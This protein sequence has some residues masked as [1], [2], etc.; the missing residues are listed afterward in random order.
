[1][2][3][4]NTL[5]A[6]HPSVDFLFVYIAEAH[7]ADLWPIGL[8]EGIESHKTMADRLQQAS[9]FAQAYDLTM[10]VVCD[11][12]DNSVHN[13]FAAWPV[14][15]YI[16]GADGRLAFKAMPDPELLTYLVSEFDDALADIH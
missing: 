8:P 7:S 11:P 16:V 9:D 1:M 3:Y 12:F 2:A 4:L 6:K 14:R 13:A 15:Y 10:P 5:P